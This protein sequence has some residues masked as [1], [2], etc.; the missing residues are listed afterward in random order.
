MNFFCIADKASSLGFMLC[1]VETREVDTRQEAL[2]ALQVARATK[3]IGVILVTEKAAALVKE[4]ISGHIV[5]NP[6]PLII[7]IPS[8]GSTHKRAG[9][10][11]LLKQLVGIGM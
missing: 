10:G 6:L 9:A 4:E 5:E 1:G 7:E 2:E 3:D 8:S 11:E